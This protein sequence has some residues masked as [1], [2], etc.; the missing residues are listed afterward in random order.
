MIRYRFPSGH[1]RAPDEEDEQSTGFPVLDG[2]TSRSM[3]EEDPGDPLLASYEFRLRVPAPIPGYPRRI[4]P[5][6]GYRVLN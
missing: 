2:Q 6:V 3:F 1:Q 5:L 4:S